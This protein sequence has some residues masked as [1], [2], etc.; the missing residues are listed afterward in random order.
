[1]ETVFAKKKETA[2]TVSVVRV[3]GLEPPR[4]PART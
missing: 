2:M 3:K 4:L 1:M